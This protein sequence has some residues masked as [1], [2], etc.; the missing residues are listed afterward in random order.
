MRTTPIDVTNIAGHPA[1]SWR[2]WANLISQLGKMKISLL[3]TLSAAA[4]HLL[5]TGKITIDVLVPT[6]SV[7]LLACG[8]CGLN[9]YQERKIDQLMLRTRLRPIPSG[10]LNPETALFISL[11]LI[12]SGFVILLYGANKIA[13]C[14]GMFAVAWYNGVYTYLKEKTAFAAVPGALVG[15]IPPA[16]GWVTGGGRILDPRMGV[17]ALFFFLWQIPH[18]WLLLLDSSRDYERTGLPCIT[19]VLSAKQIKRIIFIWL[20]STGVSSLIIPLFGLLNSFF[21]CLLLMA[22]ACWLFLNSVSFLKA[23]IEET[24]SR[25]IFTKLNL[26]ILIVLIL[27]SLNKALAR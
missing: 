17:I 15:A 11:G 14:L 8:S 24:I 19:K 10:R 3:A 21:S 4:G 7:F 6:A 5:A 18:F 25:A 13:L 27:L 23:D 16:L 2:E 20:L 1:Y 22:A 26:F 12:L 9:Q